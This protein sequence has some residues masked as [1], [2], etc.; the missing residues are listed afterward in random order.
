MAAPKHKVGNWSDALGLRLGSAK[1]SIVVG[2]TEEFGSLF[3]SYGTNIAYVFGTRKLPGQPLW[4]APIEEKVTV[5][6]TRKKGPLSQLSIGATLT[7]TSLGD[8][9]GIGSTRIET[10]TYDYYASF[11]VW[12]GAGPASKLL[13]LWLNDDLIYDGS[14]EIT[15]PEQLANDEQA[16]RLSQAA[17][18]QQQFMS[19]QDSRLPYTFYY[20]TEDQ[21]VDGIIAGF[22]G[23]ENT[24][25]Y[26]GLVYVVFHQLKLVNYDN[27][28]P[29]VTAEMV[30]ERGESTIEVTEFPLGTGISE[31]SNIVDWKRSLFITDRRITNNRGIDVFDNEGNLIRAPSVSEILGT[32]RLAAYDVERNFSYWAFITGADQNNGY[33]GARTVTNHATTRMGQ[34]SGCVI[35]N[36]VF[37]QDED[38]VKTHDFDCNGVAVVYA[39]DGAPWSFTDSQTSQVTPNKSQDADSGFA[40]TIDMNLNTLSIHKANG[41]DGSILTFPSLAPA[42]FGL[43]SFNT[44]HDADVNF[45]QRPHTFYAE[46]VNYFCGFIR[47]TI[48]GVNTFRLFAWNEGTGA[49]VWVTTVPFGR[50]ST[51]NGA[52]TFDRVGSGKYA[53]HNG[54]QICAVTVADG[55]ITEL[56]DGVNNG[57]ANMPNRPSSQVYDDNTST[58]WCYDSQPALVAVKLF[59]GN[60][61][62]STFGNIVRRMASA[63]GLTEGIDFDVSASDSIPI[64]GYR[65]TQT[66]EARKHLDPLIELY[67]INVVD[68]DHRIYFEPRNGTPIGAITVE[69]MLAVDKGTVF[70]RERVEESSL[71]QT[72][73]VEYVD[74]IRNYEK[75]IQRASRPKY[76]VATT[77]SDNTETLNIDLAIGPTEARQRAEKLMYSEWVERNSYEFGLPWT[78]LRYSVGDVVT[79]TQPSG[80]QSDIMFDEIGIG[81]NFTMQVH[82]LEQDQGQYVSFAKSVTGQSN[83]NTRFLSLPSQGFYLNLPYLSDDDYNTVHGTSIGYW[84]A[85]DYG[86]GSDNFPG[87]FLFESIDGATFNQKGTTIRSP[88]W[89]VLTADFAAPASP[90]VTDHATL[91]T[92]NMIS[93][94]LDA[95]A[96]SITEDQMLTALRNRAVILHNNG[97]APELIY[98]QTVTTVDGRT[99][100]LSELL[101]G[102]RGTEGHMACQ[103][104]DIVVFLTDGYFDDNVSNYITFPNGV[105]YTLDNIGNQYFKTVTRGLPEAGTP[106]EQLDYDCAD[107]K[108]YAPV[109]IAAETDSTDDITLSWFRRNR[110]LG[111]LA[112][113]VDIPMS[114][115]TE[116]YEIDI[117]NAAGG[118]VLRTLTSTTN[119]VTYEAGDVFD[120][121]GEISPDVIK[122]AVY[123][124]S[125]QVGRGFGEITT[126]E[127]SY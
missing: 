76:P 125:A 10:T 93:G 25:A 8:A 71:P 91:L 66:D 52:N 107:L 54:S 82:T 115:A 34:H 116:A 17:G 30:F 7:G 44:G 51:D 111:E 11:A 95:T 31:I 18:V 24:P 41:T 70:K 108:P 110:I 37:T 126:L 72:Y 50:F 94:T 28:V 119:A 122:V 89:G 16:A 58:I 20:G 53:W 62:Y 113:L 57:F 123:Q 63:A 74:Y 112:D 39:R 101:R 117:Y 86:T 81:A 79:F 98:F 5:K 48:D 6:V 47:G 12:F 40:Y 3:G 80:F 105:A 65:L 56:Y 103:A 23:L 104:G 96:D 114:E 120:D 109:S 88:R 36:I 97:S 102:R 99:A 49:L 73:E 38:G 59:V 106:A 27:Q 127:V 42:A 21:P 78:F 87:A 124:M 22:D 19:Q 118:T 64:P 75:G 83:P 92:V 13:R 61:G 85:A 67:Q 15:D 43:D 45:G 55:A 68:R 100:Q 1:Q 121:Y 77:N 60:Q 4:A 32:N 33:T 9:L 29:I 35:G 90:W 14:G 26:R 2:K 69:D 46:G 84:A